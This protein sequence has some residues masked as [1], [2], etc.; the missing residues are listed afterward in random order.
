MFLLFKS[1]IKEKSKATEL[2]IAPY[3]SQFSCLKHDDN[4]RSKNSTC[5]YCSRE[6]RKKYYH[7]DS[8]KAQNR[9]DYE[10]LKIKGYFRDQQVIKDRREYNKKYSRSEEGKA[11]R[12]RYD[13]TEKG[14][15][16]AKRRQQAYR[17]NN[18]EARFKKQYWDENRRAAKFNATPSWNN[19]WFTK[20]IFYRNQ[21]LNDVLGLKEKGLRYEVD[22]IIPLKN[23]NVCG[24]HVWYNLKP[25]T[26]SE[27]SRKKDNIPLQSELDKLPS[28]DKWLDYVIDLCE[29][30]KKNKI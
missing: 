27:N 17:K 26:G 4:L 20:E 5:V 23:R 24:L 13:Q 30:I 15:L 9:K 18:P 14:K 11:T 29:S 21:D 19:E 1:I 25:I 10:I 28:P 2:G 22:H 7:T 12:K 8:G 16:V 6:Y 3:R